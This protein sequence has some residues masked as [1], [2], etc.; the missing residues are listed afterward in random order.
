P[1][2]ADPPG[3]GVLGGAPDVRRPEAG[4]AAPSVPPRDP[5][6]APVPPPVTTPPTTPAPPDRWCPSAMT[7]QLG[8]CTLRIPRPKL[9]QPTLP[10][11]AI[12][13]R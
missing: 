7:W 1:P 9:P 6:V 3:G 2:A 11:P 12:P 13:R 8:R 4:S 5:E 10:R